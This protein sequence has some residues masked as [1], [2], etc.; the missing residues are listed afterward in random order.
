MKKFGYSTRKSQFARLVRQVS[1]GE[2]ELDDGVRRR[3]K[4]SIA[5]KFWDTV[6]A[7]VVE[8]FIE[9]RSI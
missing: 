2:A 3:S 7:A 4:A 1:A 9:D 8:H 5:V 6:L